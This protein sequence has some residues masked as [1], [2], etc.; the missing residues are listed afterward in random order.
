MWTDASPIRVIRLHIRAS[1]AWATLDREIATGAPIEASAARRLR[2]E[3]LLRPEERSGIA[4][5]L[6]TILDAAEATRT[7]RRS[8]AR[9]EA[10]AI[11]AQRDRLVELIELL[12]SGTPMTARAVAAA[13]LLACDC[14]GPLLRPRG[15]DAI[16]LALGEITPAVTQSTSTM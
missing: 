16:A 6:R 1:W 4:A 10:D 15:D 14:H 9:A 11:V 13:E 12:R 2:A 5:A 8:G 3:Q 7:G